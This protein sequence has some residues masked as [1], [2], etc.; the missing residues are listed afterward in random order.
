MKSFRFKEEWQKY[1][2]SLG[3]VVLLAYLMGLLV[4][5]YIK[6]NTNGNGTNFDLSII[7]IIVF[8]TIILITIL[9]T[10]TYIIIFTINSKT[11]DIHEM[12]PEIKQCSVFRNIGNLS[13]SSKEDILKWYNIVEYSEIEQIEKQL[14]LSL[15]HI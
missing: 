11:I 9:I 6:S 15:I 4:L 14:D 2:K 12:F 3:T 13:F 8:F 7:L 1:N 5:N 10:I